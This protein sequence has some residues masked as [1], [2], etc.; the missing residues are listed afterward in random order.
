VAVVGRRTRNLA[1]S[2]EAAE[3]D[4]NLDETLEETEAEN[5]VIMP[6]ITTIMLKHLCRE[7]AAATQ[8]S[9]EVGLPLRGLPATLE[10]ARM[11]HLN[12]TTAAPTAPIISQQRPKSQRE[13]AA[14]SVLLQ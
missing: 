3:T 14:A 11:R 13:W 4:T 2:V 8:D 5:L 10:T 9:L 7:E 12:A 6:L 1:N